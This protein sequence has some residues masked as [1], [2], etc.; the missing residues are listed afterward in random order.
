MQCTENSQ[1]PAEVIKTWESALIL[2]E[3]LKFIPGWQSELKRIGA[4]FLVNY[5]KALVTEL[6][7]QIF[8][9]ISLNLADM[10]L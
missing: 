10:S 3:I 2:K 6:F 8:R 1:G 4:Q 7:T 9:E 5:T